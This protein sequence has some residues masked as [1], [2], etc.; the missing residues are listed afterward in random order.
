MRMTGRSRVLAL[1]PVRPPPDEVIHRVL[2]I[3]RFLRCWDSN[4]DVLRRQGDGDSV[5]AF[6]RFLDGLLKDPLPLHQEAQ[7]RGA[8]S[9]SIMNLSTFICAM[10]AS[11]ASSITSATSF[12]EA[13]ARALCL[14]WW[15]L[16]ID[17]Q[18]LHRPDSV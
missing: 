1:E 10:L 8:H 14:S 5:V 18:A 3:P 15:S 7:G 4:C 6:P 11:S 17:W 16:R 12:A 2:D 13:L 9:L